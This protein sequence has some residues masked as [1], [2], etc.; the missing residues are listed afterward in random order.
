MA[1]LLGRSTTHT[2]VEYGNLEDVWFDM[3][4]DMTANGG[5]GTIG[6][7]NRTA[8]IAT[9]GRNTVIIADRPY[10][11][12]KTN[13]FSIVSSLTTPAY[14]TSMSVVEISGSPTFIALGGPALTLDSAYDVYFRGYMQG[15]GASPTPAAP[16][17]VEVRGACGDIEI[18][19]S[20]EQFTGALSTTGNIQN[21][22]LLARM[23]QASSASLIL[24]DGSTGGSPG[25]Q[26]G[27]I[28]LCPGSSTAH[29]LIDDGDGTNQAG[30]Y[31]VDIHLYPFQ[32]IA[33]PAVGS[34]GCTIR[35]DADN[36]T[37]SWVP[38]RRGNIV[39]TRTYMQLTGQVRIS[40]TGATFAAGSANG[41][42][43]PTPNTSS[44]NQNR[45]DVNFGSGTGP[46]AG[47]QVVVTFGG[48]VAYA[49]IPKIVI[50][51]TNQATYDLGLYIVG[52]STSTT[53]F[54][55]AS[56]N[57]PAAGQAVGTYSFNYMILG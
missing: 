49:A 43:P 36:P 35:S 18:H 23:P 51:P 13:V 15:R 48:T 38:E 50:T 9:V 47:A 17:A 20:I 8:E 57:A 32:S 41:T 26:G 37:I 30:I 19:G 10:V 54:T 39:L 21:L 33:A 5:A 45:G 4:S 7:Y 25:I 28:D 14:T 31:D 2:T 52:S 53:A 1:I 24:L 46:S 27:K 44:A 56:K 34:A 29:A 11:A 22:Q 12:T 6:I 42:S 16:Y 40:G 55:V 3:H